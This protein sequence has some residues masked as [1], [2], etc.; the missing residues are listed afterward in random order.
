MMRMFKFEDVKDFEKHISLS[1]PNYD[2]LV[3]VVKAI[4]LEYLDDQGTM[5]DIGCSSGSLLNEICKYSNAELIGCDLVDMNYEKNF[6]F[7]QSPAEQCLIA[8]DDLSVITSIFTL[9]FMGQTEREATLRLIAAHV[10]NGAVAIIA[11]KI[12]LNDSRLDS[13]IFRQHMRTKLQHFTAAEILEKDLQ[14]AGSMFP[15][16]SAEIESELD[17]LGD[18]EQIWQ[19]Y[20]FK[21]WVVTKRIL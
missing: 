18:Y 17:A 9:Q 5:L 6:K 12:H 16:V 21:C 15:R 1:I 14:L 7:Y 19:S 4:T 20:N 8:N 2:G 11:E 13:A 10:E 3:E